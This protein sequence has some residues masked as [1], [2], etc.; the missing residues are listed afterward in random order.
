MTRN[1]LAAAAVVACATFATGAAAQARRAAPSSAAE[2]GPPVIRIGQTVAGTLTDNEPRTTDHG[3]FRVY[4]FTARQGEKIVATLRSPDF[5]AFLTVARSV[6]GITDNMLT[7]DDRG[8]GPKGTDSRIRFI[9]PAT[10]SYLV[11]AQALDSAGRGGYTLSLADAPL[12]T[13][14][15]TVPIRVGQTLTGRLDETDAVLEDDDSYYDSY[16][17]TAQKGQRI[18]I[19]MRADTGGIDPYLNFGRQVDTAFSSIKI[20]DD[21]GGERNARIVVTIP[22]SGAYVIRANE[23]GVKTGPYMLSIT[24]RQPGPATATPHPVALETTVNGELNDQDPQGDDDGYYDYWTYAGHAGERIRVTMSSGAFDTYVSI[25]TLDGQ[26]YHEL[27]FNDDG[28]N[29][30]TNSVLDYTLPSSGTF[31][32]RA[33]ALNGQGEGAYTLQVLPRP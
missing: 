21:G 25:G 6:G 3:P 18:Q 20:D 16:V 7:D 9:A 2:A 15:A 27:A 5:D 24:E 33:K 29:T 8:G 11:L 31:V 10:G 30:G 4:R 26:T 23:V 19:D 28:D 17:L 13:T 22:E 1:H 14:A 32:I 12:P